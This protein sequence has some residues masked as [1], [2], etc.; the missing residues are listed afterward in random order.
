MTS[1]MNPCF[2]ILH[3]SKLRNLHV[4]IYGTLR[5][6]PSVSVPVNMVLERGADYVTCYIYILTIPIHEFVSPPR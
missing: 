5:L 4:S 2:L 3:G 6:K 1:E